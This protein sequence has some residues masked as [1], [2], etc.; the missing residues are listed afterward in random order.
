MDVQESHKPMSEE[1]IGPDINRYI[2]DRDANFGGGYANFGSW[3]VGIAA[4]PRDR[5]FKDHQVKKESNL[6][7]FRKAMSSTAARSIEKYFIEQKGTKGGSGGGDNSTHFVYA[8]KT[9]DY[10]QP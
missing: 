10:T 2:M 9:M 7:I 1:K 8:Y 3:Y 5:L 6:W 4:V